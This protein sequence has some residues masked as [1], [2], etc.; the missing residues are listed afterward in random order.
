MSKQNGHDYCANHARHVRPVFMRAQQVQ[1]AKKRVAYYGECPACHV[2]VR[3]RRS[4]TISQH[5]VAARK[6]CCGDNRQPVVNR[7]LDARGGGS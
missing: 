6:V 5:Y 2:V 4:G 1:S 3:L 7:A